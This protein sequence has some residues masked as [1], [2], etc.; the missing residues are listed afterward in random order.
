MMIVVGE[1]G[2]RIVT[3]NEGLVCKKRNKKKFEIKLIIWP[4][5]QT[6]RIKVKCFIKFNLS[7][8]KGVYGNDVWLTFVVA[9]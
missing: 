7:L 1:T 6:G 3:R 2:T 5:L 4:K 8:L 9:V